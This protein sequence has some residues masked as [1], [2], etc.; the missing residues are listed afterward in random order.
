MRVTARERRYIFNSITT[1]FDQISIDYKYLQTQT[2]RRH[3][4]WLSLA[5]INYQIPIDLSTDLPFEM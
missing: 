3:A 1:L 5:R 2:V 4:E